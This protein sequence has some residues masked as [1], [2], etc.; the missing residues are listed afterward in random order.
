MT[1]IRGYHVCCVLYSV[2][3]FQNPH[4]TFPMP[5]LTIS[6]PSACIAFQPPTIAPIATA[7]A[8]LTHMSTGCNG[9]QQPYLHAS[10]LSQPVTLT[11]T[12]PQVIPNSQVSQST[13]ER[14]PQ[15]PSSNV[16]HANNST[17]AALSTADSSAG[18][19]ASGHAT[20]QPGGGF[21]FGDMTALWNNPGY[22]G[23]NGSQ[24]MQKT[25]ISDQQERSLSVMI[26]DSS[27][28][29]FTVSFRSLVM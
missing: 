3:L 16:H 8:P 15:S 1:R 29:D 19:D 28:N 6:Q 7:P 18:S 21:T 2:T 17:C 13:L 5:H 10:G 27:L 14:G 23:N 4:H 25:F 26:E 11:I 22:E 12:Q 24:V 20:G 9:F